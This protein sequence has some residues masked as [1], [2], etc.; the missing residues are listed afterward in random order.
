MSELKSFKEWM[1]AR[2]PSKEL[3]TLVPERCHC[4]RNLRAMVEPPYL[5]FCSGCDASKT[6]KHLRERGLE[7]R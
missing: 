6:V 3:S 5:V 4:G 1:D 7:P 2:V